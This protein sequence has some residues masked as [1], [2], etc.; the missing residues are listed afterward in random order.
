MKIKRKVLFLIGVMAMT[1]SSLT[2][3][4]GI[5]S[6][7][8]SPPLETSIRVLETACTDDPTT[9]DLT[10][11]QNPTFNPDDHFSPSAWIGS[12]GNTEGVRLTM[13][14]NECLTGWKVEP[15]IT[16]F[17]SEEGNVISS[18]NRFYMTTPTYDGRAL[19][20]DS[21]INWNVEHPGTWG[22]LGPNA[23]GSGAYGQHIYFGG[24]GPDYGMVARA[25]PL[26][27]GDETATGEMYGFWG[28]RWGNVYG[29][30]ETPP[31]VYTG[32]LKMTFTPEGP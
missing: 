7:Q 30:K 3:A 24:T 5:S 18:T 9:L 16:D 32:T 21:S 20:W 31:G 28:L 1:M 12:S 29:I 23:T 11:S 26:L 14:I 4:F 25:Y 13:D 8:E 15:T 17:T 27:S 19:A 6:A 22:V 10:V 2:L